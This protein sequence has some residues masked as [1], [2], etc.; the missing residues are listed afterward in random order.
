MFDLNPEEVT[1]ARKAFGHVQQPPEGT[2]P[3]ATTAAFLFAKV[4]KVHCAYRSL[5]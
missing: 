1:E 4:P 5:H 3:N 2:G